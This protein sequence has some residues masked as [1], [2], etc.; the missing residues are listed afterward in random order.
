M[1]IV[2][3]TDT[4]FIFSDD[5]IC[6]TE[7]C[8]LAGMSFFQEFLNLFNF[9]FDQFKFVSFKD[10]LN[11]QFDQFY[12]LIPYFLCFMKYVRKKRI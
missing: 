6:L 7:G 5:D 12:T 4:L 1:L 3:H 8:V 10:S 9:K 2:S 11:V